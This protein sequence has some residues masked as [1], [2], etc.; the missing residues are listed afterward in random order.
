[1]GWICHLSAEMLDHIR[2]NTHPK[3]ILHVGHV[4]RSG[5]D[6]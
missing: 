6:L 5:E 2:G 1:M 3:I 4:E